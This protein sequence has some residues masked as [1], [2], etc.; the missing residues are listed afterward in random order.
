[1]SESALALLEILD[2]YCF[3]RTLCID[4]DDE[5]MGALEIRSDLVFSL[6]SNESNLISGFSNEKFD[7]IISFSDHKTVLQALSRI[8][9]SRDCEMLIISDN[10]FTYNPSSSRKDLLTRRMRSPLMYQIKQLFISFSIQKYY[11][12]PDVYKPEMI[13]SYKGLG[14]FYFRYWSWR[15]SKENRLAKILESFFVNLCRSPMFSPQIIIKLNN[16]NT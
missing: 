11:P 16:D 7:L 3:R 5:L 13:L 2:G 8:E 4:V 12:F 10:F 14:D 9:H 6:N 15:R 1:M